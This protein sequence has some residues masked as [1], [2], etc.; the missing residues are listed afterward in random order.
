MT[1]SLKNRYVRNVKLIWNL[2]SFKKKVVRNDHFEN[3]IFYSHINRQFSLH[4][5]LSL[6][7]PNRATVYEQHHRHAFQNCQS[8]IPKDN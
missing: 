4:N 6:T 1:L 8:T 5:K 2:K 7:S 3:G